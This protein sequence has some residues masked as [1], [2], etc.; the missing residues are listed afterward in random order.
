MQRPIGTE[1]VPRRQR[2]AFP[3]ALA[4]GQLRIGVLDQ[5]QVLEQVSDQLGQL[6]GGEPGVDRAL[7]DNPQ[8]ILERQV[9]VKAVADPGGVG[10][11]LEQLIQVATEPGDPFGQHGSRS[12]LVSELI[13]DET[14]LFARLAGQQV[15]ARVGSALQVGAGMD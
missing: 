1:L 3:L 4:L 15:T 7:D 6:V 8:R 2:E 9:Q 11:L 14:Q 5:A 13:L 10:L 12:G